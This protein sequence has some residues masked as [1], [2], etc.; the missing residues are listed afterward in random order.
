MRFIPLVQEDGGG[1]GLFGI[2]VGELDIAH[3]IREA[4]TDEAE[5]AI[6]VGS[7]AKITHVPDYRCGHGD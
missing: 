1:G 5:G 7:G 4:L 2:W 3:H 6:L